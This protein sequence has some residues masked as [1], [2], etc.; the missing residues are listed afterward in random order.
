VPS[1]IGLTLP[2][3]ERQIQQSKLKIGRIIQQASLVYPT[4]HVIRTDPQAGQTPPVGTAVTI[5]VSTGKP[6]VAVPDVGGDSEAAAKAALSAAGFSSITTST[7]PSSAV[8][9][10]DVI[11]T[12]PGAGTKVATSTTIDLVLATTP[13]TATVPKVTGDNEGTAMAA[14]NAAGFKVKV[15]TKTV[16]S[17]DKQGIV[18]SQTPAANSTAQKNSTVTIVV[19]KFMSQQTTTTTTTTPTTTTTTS[20]H[21]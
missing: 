4:G 14:L 21:T 2:V 6:L 20:S 16:T 11:N 3:A 10:G 18:L 17:Q 1:V 15:S 5:I 19:G 7:Q 9:Q 8:K 12:I 13:T